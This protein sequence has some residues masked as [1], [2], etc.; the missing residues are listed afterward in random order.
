MAEPVAVAYNG[1]SKLSDGQI[2]NA[3]HILVVGAGTIGMLAMLWLKYRG[4]RHV[5]I[6][7]T[8]DSR[9]ALARRM[10]ADDV[11][12]PASEDFKKNYR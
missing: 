9:L 6:S 5:I 12:N 3:D 10:G 1:V 7:D 11:V 8:F 2:E 4:A